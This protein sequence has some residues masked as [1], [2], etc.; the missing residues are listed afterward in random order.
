MCSMKFW[1]LWRSGLAALVLS[2]ALP[3]SGWAETPSDFP[4]NKLRIGVRPPAPTR[5]EAPVASESAI[6]RVEASPGETGMAA[7]SSDSEANTGSSGDPKPSFAATTPSIPNQLPEQSLSPAPVSPAE[8][9]TENLTPQTMEEP[10]EEPLKPIP[11]AGQGAPIEV[12]AASFKSVTPGVS[13]VADVQTHWG[14]PVEI[15]KHLGLILHLYKVD[16]FERVEV[17]VSEEKVSSIV[18]RLDRPFPADLVAQQLELS[19][20]QPVLVSNELGEV[21]G[22]SFPERGVLFA[23]A[24]SDA[25]GKASMNVTQ[26][27]LEPVTAEPFLLRAETLLDSQP[28]ASLKDLDQAIKMSPENGRAH[29]LRARVLAANGESDAALAAAE[30]SVRWEAD[31]PR[32]WVTRGQILASVD[33]FAEAISFVE[34]AVELSGDSP[35]V[36]AR[37]LCMLG[38]LYG[39]GAQPD[40]KKAIEY[41]SQAIQ[42]ADPLVADPHPALR[43]AAKEVMIDAHLGA[44]HDVA[45]GVWNQKDVS[46]PRWLERAAAFAKDLIDSD[47]GTPEHQLRVATRALSASVGMEGKLDPTQWAE[48]ASRVGEQWIASASETQKPRCQWELGM[49][50]YDAVQVCQLRKEDEAALRYG[51]RAVAFLE[52][53]LQARD[54]SATDRYLLGRLYFRIGAIHAVGSENHSSAIPWFEKAIP[55]L[56]AAAPEVHPSELGRLGETFVSMGVSHWETG[57]RDRAVSLTERGV[58]LLEE[59]VKNGTAEKSTLEIPYGNL[60]SMHK[61]L[62]RMDVAGKLLEKASHTSGSTMRR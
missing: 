8:T 11:A 5:S 1:L 47:G 37:A 3:G 43:L 26:I 46:V 2:L 44:A 49:A 29:W 42:I 14:A 59:A 10:A 48:E 31:N 17:V 18:I 27:I 7:E 35:H 60:A 30:Q 6:P 50:L 38:D 16:P 45:W 54:A 61:Q 4:P 12:H 55:V 62:G 39:S 36:K 22:Q 13:T 19:S 57:Q 32:Y 33:R 41:H 24:P 51:Q 34:K 23:F 58:G 20:M 53:S 9:A 52:Q 21:L 56:E 15:T 28:E 25:P 40:Y